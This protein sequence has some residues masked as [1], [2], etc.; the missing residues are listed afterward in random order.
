MWESPIYKF[1]RRREDSQGKIIKEEITIDVTGSAPT[2]SVP[3]DYLESVFQT[4]LKGKNP[5][6]TI[7]VDFGAAKLRNTLHLL[8][9]G[10]YVNAVEFKELSE[11]MPQAKQ[12]W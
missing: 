3:G 12:N 11:K 8:N 2:M 1:E 9:K 4:I 7:I 5:S 10:Y 6:R